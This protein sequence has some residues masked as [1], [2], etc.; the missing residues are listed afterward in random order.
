M[1]H[2]MIEIINLKSSSVELTQLTLGSKEIII[3]QTSQIG[4]KKVQI[5]AVKMDY[6]ASDETEWKNG[7][8]V[9]GA[10]KS[11][12]RNKEEEKIFEEVTVENFSALGCLRNL[13]QD[14]L[15]ESLQV[16]T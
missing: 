9:S 1:K 10:L 5:M 15:Q 13:R 11:E 4:K 14:K 3:K 6:G 7:K 2:I 16:N 8:C 12:Y